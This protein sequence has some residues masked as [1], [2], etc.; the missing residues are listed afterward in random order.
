MTIALYSTQDL[1]FLAKDEDKLLF[2]KGT[3]F[4]LHK[5]L[6]QTGIYTYHVYCSHDESRYPLLPKNPNPNSLTIKKGILGYDLF[7]CTQETT[8]TMI[9][10]DNVAF[11]DFVKAFD[12]ELENDMHVYSTEP[13]I[14]P[15][16]EN[17]S[18][19]RVSETAVSQND[20]ATDFSSEEKSQ[21][22][23]MPKLAGD[24]K[25]KQLD[26]KFFLTSIQLN[27]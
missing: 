6:L 25:R 8:Q 27:A 18:Q 13:Y 12:S 14:F 10:V 23:R 11:L 22:P 16:T 21:Q 24:T 1:T 7:D 20:L 26:E 3:S 17:D 2:R 19:N 4:R 15:S 5:N 9:V